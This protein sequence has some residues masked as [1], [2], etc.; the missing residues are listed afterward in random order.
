MRAA[1][2]NLVLDFHG[3][4]IAGPDS[5][6]GVFLRSLGIIV[7]CEAL[8]IAP[9]SPQSFLGRVKVA[10][11]A[12]RSGT[13]LEQRRSLAMDQTVVTAVLL[14]AHTGRQIVDPANGPEDNGVIPHTR[15]DNV[16]PVTGKHIDK[17]LQAID[18]DHKPW[19]GVC[20]SRSQW[21]LPFFRSTTRINIVINTSLGVNL[22][23]KV[24][25]R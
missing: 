10:F 25:A 1:V 16:I 14:I 24:F 11:P 17:M 22:V 19:M 4:K 6:K 15:T 5:K 7:E 3:P 18:A 21:P 13:I 12:L 23:I 9:R 8:A 2:Q 20:P